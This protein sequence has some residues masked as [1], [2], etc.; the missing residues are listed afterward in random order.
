MDLNSYDQPQDPVDRIIV[1]SLAKLDGVALGISLG[2][3]FGLI[4]FAATN[5]LIFKGGEVVGPNLSLLEQ[6]FI[7]YEV[8]FSG[9]IVGFVYGVL[10]G[11][12]VGWLIATLRNF[13][14][15]LYIHFLKVRG[16]MSAVNDYIDN[17]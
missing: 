16:S 7:G 14:V 15:S 9:S 11:F 12:I 17:P 10:V 5:I 4:I 13:V 3:I 8:T 1:E 2:L 6:Y